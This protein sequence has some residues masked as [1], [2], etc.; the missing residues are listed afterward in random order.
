MQTSKTSA[1]RV[2]HNLSKVVREAGGALTLDIRGRT[3]R[4]RL[5]RME[6]QSVWKLVS[7]GSTDKKQVNARP[8][9]IIF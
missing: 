9:R 7:Q 4:D 5:S 2:K 1:V 6:A 8:R 3:Q